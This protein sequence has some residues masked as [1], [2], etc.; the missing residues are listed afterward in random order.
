MEDNNLPEY[1]KKF[2]D[3]ENKKHTEGQKDL[4]DLKYLYQY[5][6]DFDKTFR[7]E[8]DLFELQKHKEILKEGQ[9]YYYINLRPNGYSCPLITEWYSE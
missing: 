6:K 5:T 3:E 4:K 1:L 2:I 7:K 8:L 9:S